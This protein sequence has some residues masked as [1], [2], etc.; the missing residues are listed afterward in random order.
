MGMNRTV[1]TS[2]NSIATFAWADPMNNRENGLG[3]GHFYLL[4]SSWPTPTAAV[5]QVAP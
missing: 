2:V 4:Q 3:F 5:G 1:A